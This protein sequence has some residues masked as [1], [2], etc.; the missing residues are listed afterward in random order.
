MAWDKFYLIRAVLTFFIPYSFSLIQQKIGAFIHKHRY[1]TLPASETKNVVVIGGSFAGIQIV[2]R[3]TQTLPTGY[4]VILI[5]KT[6]HFNYIFA[7]PRFSVVRGF[8]KYAFIPYD[9]LAKG[10]PNGIFEQVQ[11]VATDTTAKHVTLGSGRKIGYSYLVIAT[12]TSSSLPSKIAS[13]D[14]LHGI[15]ELMAMQDRIAAAHNIAIVGGGAVG[16]ELASDIKSFC[17]EK[18]VTLLHSRNQILSHF[19]KRLHEYTMQALDD[20]GVSVLL[21]TRP[22]LPADGC[23]VLL[24]NGKEEEFDLVVSLRF[25]S[26]PDML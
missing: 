5:E 6:S 15:S 8:E 14:R 4:R 2:K 23:K 22:E 26:C 25:P 17:P 21:N 3:L 7:F 19:G 9:G 24:L 12:G 20:L 11:D 1:K 16:V 18:D 10:A 13:T